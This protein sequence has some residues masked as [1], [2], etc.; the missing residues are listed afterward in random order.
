MTGW[1]RTNT[2]V[3][4]K[5]LIFITYYSE[6]PSPNSNAFPVSVALGN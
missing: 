2:Y 5:S 6:A 1:I 4:R 3:L